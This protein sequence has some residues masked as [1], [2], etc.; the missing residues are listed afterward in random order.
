MSI[1]AHVITELP[2]QVC[3]FTLRLSATVCVC[4]HRR[5]ISFSSVFQHL[6][7]SLTASPGQREHLYMPLAMWLAGGT[8]VRT[9]TP[10]YW[11]AAR[12]WVDLGRVGGR[13][14]GVDSACILRLELLLNGCSGSLKVRVACDQ[15][16]LLILQEYGEYVWNLRG[17]E[18][19]NH[20]ANVPLSNAKA[21]AF[22]VESW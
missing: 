21:A 5:L 2:N 6:G 12:G 14:V 16:T 3:A 10:Y 7:L 11:Q 4:V 17:R 18:A 1:P 19:N 8:S 9:N 22:T 13:G 20:F 15:N